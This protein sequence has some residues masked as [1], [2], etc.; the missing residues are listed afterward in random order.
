MAVDYFFLYCQ[1]SLCLENSLSREG[2]KAAEG[3]N[4]M[5]GA[6]GIGGGGCWEGRIYEKSADTKHFLIKN[7]KSSTG[8]CVQWLE[9]QPMEQ[10]VRGW[11]PRWEPISGL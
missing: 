5:P 9:H 10:R 7:K 11:I 8:K 2:A 6:L 4:N 1:M 3:R